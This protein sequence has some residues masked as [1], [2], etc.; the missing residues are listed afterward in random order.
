MDAVKRFFE[1]FGE[2]GVRTVPDR[3]I[4]FFREM[5]RHKARRPNTARMESIGPFVDWETLTDFWDAIAYDWR[6][7][8]ERLDAL[9][10]KPKPVS[11][12][13]QL[14]DTPPPAPPRTQGRGE[15]RG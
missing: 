2:V 3:K 1:Q 14:S 13:V 5:L 10:A 9:E 7:L 15:W 11:Y 8:D 12:V 6:G 4:M